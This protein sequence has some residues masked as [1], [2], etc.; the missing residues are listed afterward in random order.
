M[1]S[2]RAGSVRSIPDSVAASAMA[3]RAFCFF[4]SASVIEVRAALRDCPKL[5]FSSLGM[6]LMSAPARESVPF[7]PRTATRASSKERTS[8]A[9]AMSSRA[10]D[11]ILAICSFM[12][13]GRG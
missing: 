8:L 13:G 5:A 4:S 2:E 7:F 1:W 10:A 3:C 12:G 11:W 6:S 9:A